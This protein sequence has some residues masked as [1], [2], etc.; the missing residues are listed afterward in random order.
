VVLGESLN[1]SLVP[2]FHA[3][4]VKVVFETIPET[5]KLGKPV[6]L[7]FGKFEVERHPARKRRRAWI[8]NRVI[9]TYR[10]R[11]Y[12]EFPLG[13]GWLKRKRP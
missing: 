2:G 8:R 12:I 6:E 9:V 11:K 1:I 5:L 13:T 3:R 4:V 7:P 10:K